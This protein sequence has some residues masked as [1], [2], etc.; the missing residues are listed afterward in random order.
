MNIYVRYFDHEDV[1]ASG[2][3]VVNYLVDIN[4]FNMTPQIQDEVI[5]YSHSNMPFP[6]RV[7]VRNNVYFILIKTTA[8]NL[9][10]FKAHKKEATAAN[11]NADNTRKDARLEELHN[12]R[13]GWYKCEIKFKRVVLIPGTQKCSYRDTVFSA[14]IYAKSGSECYNLIIDHLRNR[15]EI[16][17]RSQFPSEKK[18][19]FSFTYIGNDGPIEQQ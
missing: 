15:Q 16:D 12:E 18:A 11:N 7:K 2:Q 1:F 14:Y 4:D 6:K 3:D 5:S 9:P 10:D 19:N 8:D 17:P 13:I